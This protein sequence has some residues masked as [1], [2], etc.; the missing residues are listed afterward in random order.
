MISI[1]MPYYNKKKYIE[2]SLFSILDQTFQD[3]E[4]LII[5]DDEQKK[6]L[7]FIQNLIK[8]R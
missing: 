3:F 4:I 6:D 7:N 8:K 1:I 5:Y 2:E